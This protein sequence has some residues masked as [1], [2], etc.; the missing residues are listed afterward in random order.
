MRTSVILNVCLLSIAA[1]AI[2]VACT[3]KMVAQV[4]PPL[5]DEPAARFS[6]AAIYGSN[7]N[8]NSLLFDATASGPGSRYEWDFNS[9]G[10]I[11]VVT[12]EPIVAPHNVWG[13]LADAGETNVT[14]RVVF[15][16]ATEQSITRTISAE[17]LRH[18]YNNA[19]D[20]EPR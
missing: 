8:V 17:S 15:E 12:T 11:D 6:V 14:L 2:V 9:N 5:F 13:W 18:S 16:N 3:S 1:A 4:E 20:G 19:Q 10:V 7:N